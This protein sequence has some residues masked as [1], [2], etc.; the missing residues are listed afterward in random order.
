MKAGLAFVMLRLV[1][2]VGERHQ[3]GPVAALKRKG[4]W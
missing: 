1:R 2:T 3:G 4:R